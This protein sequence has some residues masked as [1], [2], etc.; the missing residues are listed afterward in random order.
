LD[1]SIIKNKIMKHEAEIEMLR[2]EL[3]KM[4]NII[5]SKNKQITKLERELDNL[6][7]CPDR[8]MNYSP[9]CSDYA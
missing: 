4:D 2:K 5:K 6:Y 9:T 7:T 8:K 1:L 3:I